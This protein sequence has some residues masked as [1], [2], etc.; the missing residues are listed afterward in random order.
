MCRYSKNVVF[1][2][3]SVVDKCLFVLII[4]FEIFNNKDN[5]KFKKRL[6]YIV[7]FWIFNCFNKIFGWYMRNWFFLGFFILIKIIY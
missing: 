6:V 3:E 4:Y 2:E 1:F 7:Y 5:C